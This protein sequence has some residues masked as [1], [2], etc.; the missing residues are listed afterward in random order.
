MTHPSRLASCFGV[1][2]FSINVLYP[3]HSSSFIR[4]KPGS[5]SAKMHCDMLL[6]EMAIAA[7]TIAEAASA[8][9]PAR[10][11]CG[12]PSTEYHVIVNCSHQQRADVPTDFPTDTEYI[13]FQGNNITIF[14]FPALSKL[15]K[16]DLQA[17]QL[18]TIMAD[19]FHHLPAL[20]TLILSDNNIA[21]LDASAF[22]G[23][24]ALRHLD[25][26]RKLISSTIC[27]TQCLAA[28]NWNIF[29]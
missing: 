23:M 21:S 11:T 10:C 24:L 19:S 12:Q 18:R 9:C 14:T 27:R 1:T 17:N 20:E 22:R 15:R 16:L 5:Y 6:L 29:G 25:L 26:E 28:S 13:M 2:L 7:T 4:L 3:R 8:N